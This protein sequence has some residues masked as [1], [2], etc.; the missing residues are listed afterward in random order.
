MLRPAII[1][2]FSW[3]ACA[4]APRDGQVLKELITGADADLILGEPSHLSDSSTTRASD[5]LTYRCTYQANAAEAA[6]GRLGAIYYLLEE[7]GELKAAQ[8]K[9]A[10][11]KAA[12]AGHEGITV[13]HDL[14]D[15]AYFHSDGTNFLFVM[16][17]KGSRV[18][19]MK[20]NKVTATTSRDAFNTTARKITDAL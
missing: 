15:E 7:Y 6:T 4:T 8:A 1:L 12:N 5:V 18:L 14:G 3:V 10:N 19:T 11:I 9:Y 20:V 2:L 13:L 17:R 16:V